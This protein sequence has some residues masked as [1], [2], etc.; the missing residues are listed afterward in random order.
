[1][2]LAI[3]IGD[4]HFKKTNSQITDLVIQKILNVIKET[5]PDFVVLLGDV[6]DDHERIHMKTQNKAIKFIKRIAKI[7]PIIVI[8]GNHDRPDSSSFL[9]EESCFY[10]LKDHEDRNI[11][12]ADRALGFN[13][14]SPEGIL[15]FVFVPYVSPGSFH[16]ALDTLKDKILD[17]KSRPSAIFCHQEFKGAKMRGHLSRYGDEWLETNPLVISGHLHTFHQPQNNIVY[18]GTPYQ[19]SYSDQTEKGILL[20]EFKVNKAPDINFYPLNIRK[21]KVIK[22]KPSEVDSFVPPSDC[23]VKIV[24]SGNH[25][26]IKSLQSSNVLSKLSAGGIHISLDPKTPINPGNPDG[27]S[28]KDLLLHMLKDDQEAIDA[29]NSIFMTTESKLNIAKQNTTLSDLLSQANNV[30][31]TKVSPDS[32]SIMKNIL[33]GTSISGGKSSPAILKDEPFGTNN[34]QLSDLLKSAGVSPI[35][36]SKP[37]PSITSKPEV[38][39][40]EPNI[41]ESLKTSASEEKPKQ[42]GMG[43][44]AA[45]LNDSN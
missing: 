23:D 19:T 40:E 37:K 32:E 12:I 8:I 2:V 31:L 11:Y 21:K 14:K 16:E 36:L 9:T 6:L 33:Q 34:I 18:A 35:P 26:E 28:Y 13:L 17:P 4:L 29:Y 41:L 43:L 38:I 5:P 1:M 7:C 20:A 30:S 15:R 24:I 45:I 44:L 39:V 25:D 22:L 10:A 27:K 3:I 42:K